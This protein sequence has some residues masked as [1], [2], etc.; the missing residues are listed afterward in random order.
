MKNTNLLF[1]LILFMF[2]SCSSNDDGENNNTVNENSLLVREWYLVSSDYGNGTIEAPECSNGN[3][4]Y[5]EFTPPN[6]YKSYTWDNDNNCD[7][8]LEASG[9]WE[10]EG[11][12]ISI[13][14]DQPYPDEQFII[15]ELTAT[16]FSY[17]SGTSYFVYTSIN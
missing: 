11:V 5:V 2:F 4:S 17:T 7:Y 3:L 14:Y 9:T 13:E 15:D 16:T 10:K 1:C 12:V 8:F 6:I